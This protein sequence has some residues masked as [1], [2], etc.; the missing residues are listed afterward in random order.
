MIMSTMKIREMIAESGKLKVSEAVNYVMM[1]LP[2]SDKKV[3]AREAKEL[4]AEAKK[5]L[6]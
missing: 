6:K 5:Y 2:D 1:R 3:V 4:I